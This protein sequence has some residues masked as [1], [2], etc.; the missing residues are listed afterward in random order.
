MSEDRKPTIKVN[1]EARAPEGQYGGWTT[2]NN[3]TFQVP[4]D[5]G[6]DRIMGAFTQALVTAL[7]FL[8]IPEPDNLL[9]AA[10]QDPDLGPR[11]DGHPYVP[12]RAPMDSPKQ[13]CVVC[14]KDLA[15]QA[16]HPA[17]PANT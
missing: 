12:N 13:R 9:P 6:A 3:A 7:E 1:V 2:V 11:D 8:G 16:Q 5:Q 4:V 15:D 17:T 10:D 14:G